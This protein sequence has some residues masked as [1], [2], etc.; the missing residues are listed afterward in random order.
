MAREDGVKAA[1]P[2][3]GPLPAGGAL[4][5][6][7]S[8]GPGAL[9]LDRRA[10]ADLATYYAYCRAIDDCADEYAPDEAVRHL[11]AWRA[12][13]DRLHK[14]R[15]ASPLGA[16]LADLCRR[17]GI[18]A[19]LLDDLWQGAKADARARVRFFRFADLRRYCYQVAGS[20]GLACLPIFGLNLEAGATYALALGEAFQLINILRDVKEDAGRGRLYFAL[21]DLDR[22]GLTE[23][24]F[25]AGRGGARA[26]RLFHAY[27]WRA[28]HNLRRAD[29]EAVRAALPGR[30]LRASRLMRVLYGDLL[31][32]M[33]ADGFRVF[34][35][36]YRLGP[37]RRAGLVVRALLRF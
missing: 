1:T 23:R 10:R 35:R 36:H 37:R 5:R 31:E 17:R 33:A 11:A 16:A 25:M 22:Y 20:V 13:L 24:E 29:E 27:A 6:A 14:G 28:R 34:E 32:S 21:E 30:R 4:I 7:S 12:E 2:G 3:L 9:F 19:G 8:F 26:E 15:P 18:P